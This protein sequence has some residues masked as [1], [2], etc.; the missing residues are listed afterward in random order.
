[1][2]NDYYHDLVFRRNAMLRDAAKRI[3]KPCTKKNIS[4]E[5][6][7]ISYKLLVTIARRFATR[8]IG[9][10]LDCQRSGVY[11]YHAPKHAQNDISNPFSF[12]VCNSFK[13][14]HSL[15]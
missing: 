1:M 13:V 9:P 5:E 4:Q 3:P 7:A 11:H 15:R 2:Q 12:R 10:T 6:P 14:E 8:S